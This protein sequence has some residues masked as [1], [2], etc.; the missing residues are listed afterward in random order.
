MP[1]TNQVTAD[2]AF[3][4]THITYTR[5]HGESEKYSRKLMSISSLNIN[6]KSL[7]LNHFTV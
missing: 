1:A 7:T 5:I 3:L 6:T 2:F 4:E